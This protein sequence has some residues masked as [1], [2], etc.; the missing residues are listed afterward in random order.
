[1]KWFTQLSDLHAL[2]EMLLSKTTESGDS[3]QFYPSIAECTDPSNRRENRF[4]TDTCS[5]FSRMP[6]N[7]I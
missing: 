4:T 2:R 7:L 3:I 6:L 5:L 1:M